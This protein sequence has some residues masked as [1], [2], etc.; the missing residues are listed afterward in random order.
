ML[1]HPPPV[2]IGGDGDQPDSRKGGFVGH[3]TGELDV[4]PEGAAGVRHALDADGPTHQLDLALTQCETESGA[5]EAVQ[6][7]RIGLREEVEDMSLRLGCDAEAGIHHL[8]PQPDH[9]IAGVDPVRRERDRS[10]RG[11]LDRVAAQVE[12]HLAKTAFVAHQPQ[13]GAW[14]DVGVDE[15]ALPARLDGGDASHR[16]EKGSQVELLQL[17]T[18]AADLD[19]RE[20]QHILDQGKLP[21]GGAVDGGDHLELARVQHG[22]L[23]KLRGADDRI[24]RSAQFVADTGEEQALGAIRSLGLAARLGQLADQ[25]E[26][27][28]RQDDEAGHQAERHGKMAVPERAL[29]DQDAEA[30]GTRQGG[31]EDIAAAEAEAVSDDDPEIDDIQEGRRFPA[32]RQHD[33]RPGDIEHDRQAAPQNRVLMCKVQRRQERH[34]AGQPRQDRHRPALSRYVVPI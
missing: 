16:A 2:G 11:E 13:R 3:V 32:G 27:I 26:R 30:C 1:H 12:Q 19:A 14:R 21:V 10:G 9:A 24:Q 4:H 23:Q 7:R 25:C 20:L 6:D 5:A 15:Q 22:P 29:N 8:Q 28:G 33:R 17:D 31:R 34:G 18:A